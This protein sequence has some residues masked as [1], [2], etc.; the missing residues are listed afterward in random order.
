MIKTFFLIIFP[1]SVA[2]FAIVVGTPVQRVLA[3]AMVCLGVFV[4]IVT[5]S[6]ERRK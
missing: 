6:Y 1:Y 3:F 5:D 4:Y 2:L